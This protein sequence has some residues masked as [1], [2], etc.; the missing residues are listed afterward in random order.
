MVKKY[1]NR[2]MWRVNLHFD[3]RM[4]RVKLYFNRRTWRGCLAAKTLAT[5]PVP[6]DTIPDSTQSRW[7]WSVWEEIENITTMKTTATKTLFQIQAGDGGGPGTRGWSQS[8]LPES[9]A[10]RKFEP[11]GR[12]VF[13]ARWRRTI[14]DKGT[15]TCPLY[16]TPSKSSA[17]ESVDCML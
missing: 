13:G 6:W 7:P 3:R 11:T 14:T 12:E 16:C 2:R 4:W 8:L 1:F 9:G 17:F 15:K 5:F 10:G